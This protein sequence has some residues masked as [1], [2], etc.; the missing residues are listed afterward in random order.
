MDPL[1]SEPKRTKRQERGY[2]WNDCEDVATRPCLLKRR[3][4]RKHESNKHLCYGCDYT[5]TTASSLKVHIKK[6][7]KELGIHA[8]NV[9]ILLLD[10]VI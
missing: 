7:M 10:Q 8:L 1:Q 5:A 6:N 2:S 4:E 3:V 9:S